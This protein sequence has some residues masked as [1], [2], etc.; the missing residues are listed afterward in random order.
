MSSD[1]ASSS[2]DAFRKRAKKL[3]GELD[4]KLSSFAK[5][6]LTY[7]GRGTVQTEDRISSKLSELDLLLKQLEQTNEDMNSSISETD[8]R[9]HTV[10]RHRDILHE[11]IQETDR[12]KSAVLRTRSQA[13]ALNENS[14]VAPLMGVQIQGTTG[15]LLRER[16]TLHSASV[17][18]D[19]VIDQASTISDSL[20]TQGGLFHRMS[21]RLME[22]GM[23][24]PV[25]NGLLRSISRRKSRDTIILS[26]VVAVC[27]AFFI[28]YICWR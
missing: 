7:D 18:I 4:V 3:E 6:C 12:L 24:Y 21:D 13:N 2:W 16:G 26:V 23:K 27:L 1:S 9:A 5:L 25:L 28:I 11:Y 20:K 8:S 15:T 22:V 17:G 10:S 19:E 14:E